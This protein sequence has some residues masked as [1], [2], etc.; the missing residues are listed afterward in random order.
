MKILELFSG[1][2]TA[3]FALKRLG[4]PYELVG[5]SDIDKFANQCFKQNHCPED[6][7]DKF[8]LG[9][10]TKINTNDLEDFDLLTGGFPCQDVSITGKGDLSKGRTTLFSE[11]IRIAEDKQPRFMLLEN[12]KGILSKKHRDFYNLTLS[13]LNRIGYEVFMVYNKNHKENRLPVLNTKDYGV[14]Q[15][16]ERVWYICFKNNADLLKFTLP[17]PINLH[18]NLQGILDKNFDDKYYLSEKV[19]KGISKSNFQDRKPQIGEVCRTLKVG[20][21]V[22]CILDPKTKKLRKLTPN[23]YFK[24]QGFKEGEINLE[25][26]SDT[27]KYKLA[28]NGQSLNVVTLLFKEMGLNK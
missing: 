15:N 18:S 25:G 4:V 28:G 9:D 2:G 16:R 11:I 1:Y 10:V 24:L 26:L 19:V 12:V 27:Q 21:D 13:E 20:G 23:E 8:R 7:E 14:P 5:Y 17:K 3:S 22:K 6:D